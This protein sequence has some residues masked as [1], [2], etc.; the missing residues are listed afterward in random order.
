M[1]RKIL[2]IG[3][4]SFLSTNLF[5]FLKTKF[6]VTKIDFNKFLKTKEKKLS[7]FNYIINCSTNNFFL[8]KQYDLKYDHDFLSAKKLKNIKSKLIIFS[9][10]KI[11]G[12]GFSLRENSKKRPIDKYGKNKLISEDKVYQLKKELLIFRVS[13]VVGKENKNSSRKITNLF[14]DEMR[15]NLKKKIIIVTK[16]NYYK[17]FILID[18]FVRIIYLSIIKNL[19][20]IFNLSTNFK[21]YLHDLAKDI[22]KYN[23]SKIKYSNSKTYSFTLNNKKLLNKIK[24][25]KLKNLRKNFYKY[26]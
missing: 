8:N 26:I 17:D 12:P 2:I 20:G 18:D 24:I 11:Y 3:K 1:K 21:I 23:G 6:S 14:F 13:N 25:K 5:K 9:T 10:S 19:K 4:H 15:K 7:T 16:I 22:S